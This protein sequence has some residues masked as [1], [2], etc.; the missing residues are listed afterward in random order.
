[1]G[2][3]IIILPRYGKIV[4]SKREQIFLLPYVFNMLNYA[5]T[6]GV[7][8]LSNVITSALFPEPF[9][10]RYV[11]VPFTTGAEI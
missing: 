9:E 8:A 7:F 3:Y 11:A 1:M 2:L 6:L 10:L 4:N 5:L